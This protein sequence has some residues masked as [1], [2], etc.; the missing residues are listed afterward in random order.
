MQPGWGSHCP[1]GHH[2]HAQPHPWVLTPCCP[3]ITPRSAGSP[4]GLWG[5][6]GRQQLCPWGTLT[7]S[8]SPDPRH[9]QPGWGVQAPLRHSLKIQTGKPSASG[10]NPQGGASQIT[11]FNQ[12]RCV[13]PQNGLW[14][15]KPSS[16]SL[17]QNPVPDP[18]CPGNRGPGGPFRASLPRQQLCGTRSRA[19]GVPRPARG[20]SGGFGGAW[21][22]SGGA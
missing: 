18:P 14:P 8:S 11:F 3:G 17:G 1:A 4:K 12:N 6:A 10:L 16:S 21:G 9:G 13:W 15:P 2:P 5:Q 7:P 19:G 22:A 20:S